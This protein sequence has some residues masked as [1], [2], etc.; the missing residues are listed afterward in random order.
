MPVVVGEF[1]LEGLEV[2]LQPTLEISGAL[3]F[4]AD[5]RAVRTAIRIFS[6]GSRLS[7]MAEAVAAEDGAFVLSGLVQGTY[8]L[9]T[10]RRSGLPW[11]VAAR[12]NGKDAISGFEVTGGSKGPLEITMAC[13]EAGVNR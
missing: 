10:G 9:D 3:K 2:V 4:G 8:R 7:G 6:R 11:P 5:C 1:G 13:A 12:L